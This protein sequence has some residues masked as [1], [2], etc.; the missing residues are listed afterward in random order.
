[1]KCPVC[2]SESYEILKSKGKHS[3]ELLLK[4]EEC[5]NIYRETIIREKPVDV[6]IVISEFEKSKKA[7]V[8]LYPDEVLM[9][10]D[11]LDLDGKEVAVNSIEIKTSAR[12]Y[13]SQVSDIETIWA[14]SMD[15]P[16]RVGISVDFGGR[17]I[18]KKVDVD[19]DF[20]FTV[21][22]IV[23]M[24]NLIFK[25]TSMKTIERKLRKG[26][27]KAYVTKRV[28]GRPLEEFVRYNYDLSS[29]IV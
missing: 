4:C 27:A 2:E 12:V 14:S 7:F 28:Y 22:D 3:K 13:R 23:K 8:K 24:G 26:F 20:E 19:R 25:I 5:G 1:M 10:D 18:S 9:V 17:V 6:R 16:A 11:I 29:N 15:I 21:G